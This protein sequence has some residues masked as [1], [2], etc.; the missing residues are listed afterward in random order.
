MKLK[1]Q[2]NKKIDKA[3]K[4]LSSYIKVGKKFNLSKQRIHQIITG[5]KSPASYDKT[6]YKYKLVINPFYKKR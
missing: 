3:Y 5:Y 1:T 4:E 2:R 6:K